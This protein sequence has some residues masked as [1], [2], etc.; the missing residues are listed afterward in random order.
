MKPRKYFIIG[1]L[2]TGILVL[3]I[4]IFIT[5]RP[6]SA[7]DGLFNFDFGQSPQSSG[8][9]GA[10]ALRRVISV[11]FGIQDTLALSTDG[12]TVTVQGHGICPTGGQNFTVDV[13]VSQNTD[14]VSGVVPNTGQNYLLEV[15]KGIDNSNGP[16]VGH[17]EGK[18]VSGGKAQWQVDVKVPASSA[19]KPGIALACGHAVVPVPGTDNYVDDWCK[20]VILK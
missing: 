15:A 11:P 6:A 2:V 10:L 13:T 9:A 14:K 16:E 3:A 8:N 18:C 12:R 7:G 17:T 19:F 20:D 4:F 1:S 5:G